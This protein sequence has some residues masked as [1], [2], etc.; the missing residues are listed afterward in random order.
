MRLLCVPH[1]GAGPSVFRAWHSAM[2]GLEIVP[3]T[4]PGRE[5][6]FS[7]PPARD[8][9]ALVDDIIEQCASWHRTPF[10]LFGHSMGALVGFE[11]A[12]ALR[13]RRLPAPERLFVSAFRAPHLPQR[14]PPLHALPDVALKAALLRL[15]GTPREVLDQPELMQTVLPTL[16]R[17]LELV[18][19]YRYRAE[20][21]LTCP[22]T[23]LAG[24]L[25]ERV[26]GAELDAWRRHT[27][28]A[29]GLRL[30]PGAHFYLYRTPVLVLRA[31]AADV[32]VGPSAPMVSVDARAAA[33][34]VRQT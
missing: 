33:R 5:S 12:R 23:C 26:T 6:R 34:R 4:L 19:R 1:A 24:V 14:R 31:I 11:L 3:V 25:D 13:R 28:G 21:P 17:D 2:P 16:R 32:G 10:A 20:P 9:T 18:E 22:V 27:K 15:Q 7:E 8:L 29:F 30:F